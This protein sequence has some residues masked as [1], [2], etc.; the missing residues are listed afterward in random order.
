MG[1]PTTTAPTTTAVT[2]PRGA[3]AGREPLPPLTP[4][5]HVP[6]SSLTTGESPR[7]NGTD[8]ERCRELAE[9]EGELPAIVVHRETMRVV[10][11]AHRLRAA[12]LRGDDL[13][14]VR[15]FDGPARDAYVLAVEANTRH[16]TPLSR[17]ERTAAATRIIASHPQWSDRAIAQVAGLSAHTVAAL[18]QRSRERTAQSNSRIGR[19]GRVRPVSSAE[20][21][22]LA[23]KLMRSDPKASLRQ[24]ADRVG[25]S[26]ATV[27]DV[28]RR[29]DRGDDPVPTGRR[30][31]AAGPAKPPV[32]AERDT[33]DSLD[34]LL[35]NLA[36]DPALRF[37]D[38]GRL[39]LRRLHRQA[40]STEEQ[41]RLL[42]DVPAHCAVPVAVF[43][44]RCAERCLEV[45][46]ELERRRC[47]PA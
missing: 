4:V 27:L 44:R 43:V 3:E 19:D 7:S 22:R 29:L 40:A 35:H 47:Q 17:A 39:L 45:A 16:G 9:T 23:G 21:R 24:I 5:T 30:T 41:A 20:S 14:A 10:D 38:A 12:E 15:F 1:K 31:R 32:R 33:Q 8:I 28:R 26:P 37:T 36:K 11:G 46:E 13:I 34:A 25:L 6:I 18:R 2:G 42:D